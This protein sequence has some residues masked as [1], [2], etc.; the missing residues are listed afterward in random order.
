M[1]LRRES[2]P[3]KRLKPRQTRCSRPWRAHSTMP[4][5]V[6]FTSR[7]P[8]GVGCPAIGWLRKRGK[9]SGD[10][11]VLPRTRSIQSAPRTSTACSTSCPRACSV[12]AT[13]RSSHS[14]SRARFGAPSSARPLRR[15]SRSCPKASRPRS[16]S[17]TDQEGEG[18]TK[19]VAYGSDPAT[20]PVRSLKDWLELG[21][22]GEGPVFRPINRR[23]QL[24]EKR[25]TDH[26]VAAIITRTA[27][28][29]GLRTP[30]LSGQS[31][32]AGF[33][34]EAKAHGADDVD[35]AAIIDQ[36]GHKSLA[37]VHRYHRRKRSR[38][39]QSSGCDRERSDLPF[40]PH[41]NC[42]PQR[43]LGS[44]QVR[45]AARFATKPGERQEASAGATQSSARTCRNASGRSCNFVRATQL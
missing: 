4:F 33:V 29:A 14:G 22:I 37:M 35:D 45:V 40:H 25:L 12:C 6:S 42:R 10:S 44:S 5:H 28:R 23:E 24:G 2:K 17:K 13:A 36:T 16:R 3:G 39:A 21:E 9:A 11:S 26:A 30:E 34:T 19:V 8:R 20:C 15:T 43:Q 1:R 41:P 32:R 7:S 38:P 31:L 27:K 18:L